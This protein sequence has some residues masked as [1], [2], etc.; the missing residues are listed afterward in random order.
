MTSA[1]RIRFENSITACP[2]RGGVALPWQSGQSGQP[3][4]E[5]VTRTRAPEQKLTYSATH[6]NGTRNANDGSRLSTRP[7]ENSTDGVGSAVV[8]LRPGLAAAVRRGGRR[9]AGTRRQ[10]GGRR[11]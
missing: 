10:R 3:R 7:G 9:R 5:L 11:R 6:V 8:R 2:A 4:P 1:A